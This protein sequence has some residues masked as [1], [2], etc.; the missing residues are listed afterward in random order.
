VEVWIMIGLAM[1]TSVGVDAAPAA[2]PT[3]QELMDPAVFPD[4]QRGMAVEAVSGPQDGEI[5]VRTTGAIFAFDLGT[6]AVTCQ[7]R[8][9]HQRPVAVL[10]TGRAWEG[11]QVTHRGPGLARITVRQPRLTVRINGDSLLMLH[12]QQ[13]LQA[14]VE[15]RL[16]VAWHSSFGSNHLLADEWGAFGLY[17][18]EANLDDHYDA[19]ADTVARYGLPA[20]GVLWVGVCPPQA[21]DWDRSCRDNVIW[22]W[23]NTQGYPPDDVLKS[24][25]PH[26]NIVLL[27]SEVMLWKDWNLDF[28]P[29]LGP[30]EFARVR[31]TL[32]DLGMRFIV[33]TSP[34]YFIKGTDVEHTALNSFE[35]FTDWPPGRTTGENM[36]L[37]MSAITRM[38]RD[39]QP[40]GLYFDGQYTENP[41]A[42][43]ALA[44]QTR[45]LLGERGLLEWH[46]TAAL[47]PQSCYLP[48][49]DAYVDF[50]LRG[51]GRAGR[52]ADDDYLR[53]FV[54]GYNISNSIGVL[55]NNGPE[56]RP[57]AEL[58][59][60]LVDVNGRYH[61]I[62]GWWLD[63]GIARV[64]DEDYKPRLRPSLQA[65]VDRGCDERQKVV[66]ER[67]ATM[68][69]ELEALDAA[70][71][72]HEPVWA[73]EFDQ[74]PAAEQLISPQNP[75]PFRL[76]AGALQIHARA[77]TYAYLKTAVG[78]PVSG[79]VVRLRLGTDGGMSWGPGV[80]LRCVNGVAARVGLRSDGLLQSDILGEQRVG[81][82]H[83][84]A[85]PGQWIWLRVRWGKQVGVF[86]RSRDGVNFERVW[87]LDNTAALTADVATLSVGKVPYNGE[88]ADS[89][90]PGAVGE[91][92][93][94]FVRL[95]DN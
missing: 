43:Y 42:L 14:H 73:L 81:S 11:V 69:A 24:W 49:A 52:Y 83:E 68:R 33:Y 40:D 26:G 62:G 75:D 60:R 37:F 46:S 92:A 8:I 44:R 88:P 55:C 61:T 16:D 86:E 7:Q 30:E 19:Y 21:Y 48:Q 36:G 71:A 64:L 47:G 66:R 89:A 94:D 50:I 31:R 63:P 34:Y 4:P 80:L 18:S 2:A 82:G 90:D 72:W 35:N 74:M 59:K 65:E 95:Y 32:H 27:Q 6:G 58:T 45:A 51:E 3:F 25:Q 91:S 76:T 79:F 77:H 84:S 85:Q 53:F 39:Y 1:L 12:A 10:Q 20:D 22:H 28:V 41:A 23:S 17:C 70:P 67:A 78:Q 5:E 38:V 9:G 87:Q 15:R 13:P 29:R 54:S 57:T 56:G 93:I